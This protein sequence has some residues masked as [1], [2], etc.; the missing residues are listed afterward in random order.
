[1]N[2]SGAAP[3]SGVCGRTEERM[4]SEAPHCGFM[5]DLKYLVQRHHFKGGKTEVWR[6]GGTFLRSH[7]D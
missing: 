6:Q 1:M 4:G 3:G 5:R 7:D 2:S